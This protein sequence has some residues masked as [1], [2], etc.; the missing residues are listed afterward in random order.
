[1]MMFAAVD[2][3]GAPRIDF[4]CNSKTGQIWLN[5][6]NPWPGSIGYFLWEAAKEPV[7]FTDLMSALIEEALKENR[8]RVLPKDP[9]PADARLFQRRG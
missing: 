5:E 8:K 2:G 1:M 3:T 9:V 7:L 4:V 6:V